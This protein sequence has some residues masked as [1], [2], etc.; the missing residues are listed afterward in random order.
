MLDYQLVK[1]FV[2]TCNE[3]GEEF[4]YWEDVLELTEKYFDKK[5]VYLMDSEMKLF[6]HTDDGFKVRTVSYMNDVDE[7]KD[8]LKDISNKI[9]ASNY[10]DGSSAVLRLHYGINQNHIFTLSLYYLHS[11]LHSQHRK[12][13][14]EVYFIDDER[15]KWLIKE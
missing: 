6:M 3:F 11:E 1:T 2:N 4:I 12:L 14:M 13:E 8:F 10:I 15:E 5:E 7:R 9:K